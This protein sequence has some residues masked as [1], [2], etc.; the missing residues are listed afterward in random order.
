MTPATRSPTLKAVRA[1]LRRYAE[2]QQA[3]VRQ[4]FFK[5]GPGE[6]GEGDKF[7]GVRVPNIRRVARAFRTLRQKQIQSLL[8][9]DWH[10]ERLVALL[11][12]V[13]QFEKGGAAE[14]EEIFQLYRRNAT[15]VNNWDLVDSSAHQI[16]GGYLQERPRDLLDELARSPLL[17]ER[18]MAIIATLTFIKA[19]DFD[20]CL[21]LARQ[22]LNDPHDLIHKGVGWMLREVGNRDEPVLRGFLDAHVDTMPRTMLRYA[23]EKLDDNTRLQYLSR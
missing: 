6:Y 10:E 18:R 19:G 16:L 14:Q 15:A 17:W 22:L 3:E 23:I 21:R 9:S 13:D 20:D 1:E 8:N 12:M 2:P 5:T 7:L 4:R 11:V